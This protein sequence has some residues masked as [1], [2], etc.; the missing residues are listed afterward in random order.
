[1]VCYSLGMFNIDSEWH[2]SCCCCWCK[3]IMYKII[4]WVGVCFARTCSMYKV[5]CASLSKVQGTKLSQLYRGFIS[6]YDHWNSSLIVCM[7]YLLVALLF[8]HKWEIQS[9][10]QCERGLPRA[11]TIFII[12]CCYCCFCCGGPSLFVKRCIICAMNKVLI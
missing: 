7:W 4:H 10:G 12:G 6:Y 1:M 11:W 3:Y 2:C 9:L 8:I 5:V